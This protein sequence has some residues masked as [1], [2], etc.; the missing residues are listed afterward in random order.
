MLEKGVEKVCVSLWFATNERIAEQVLGILTERASNEVNNMYTYEGPTGLTKEWKCP[1]CGHT[2]TRL[3][4][5]YGACWKEKCISVGTE[6]TYRDVMMNH[7]RKAEVVFVGLKKGLTEGKVVRSFWMDGSG[8]KVEDSVVLE[9]G[10][11]TVE[12]KV[13]KETRG[14][15]MRREKIEARRHRS[16]MLESVLR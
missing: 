16:P 13:V 14:Q 7:S 10:W 6:G 9:T 2:G 4:Q 12:C 11:A 15:S 5:A 1:I 8:Q 3:N